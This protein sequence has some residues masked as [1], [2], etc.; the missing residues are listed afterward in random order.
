M[1]TAERNGSDAF[2]VFAPHE[3]ASMQSVIEAVC[4]ELGVTTRERARR[5]AVADRV[6]A[7]YREGS[8][9][10]LDMV[11]AGLAERAAGRAHA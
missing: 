2:G 11:H 7:A 1:S 8:R 4:S 10:P 6:V 3:L 5:R 9:L